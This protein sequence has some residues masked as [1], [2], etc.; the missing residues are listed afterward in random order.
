LRMLDNNTHD[1]MAQ[2][3]HLSTYYV[4]W[5]SLTKTSQNLRVF[6]STQYK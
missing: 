4:R 1:H 3:V 5:Y 2:A 6:P